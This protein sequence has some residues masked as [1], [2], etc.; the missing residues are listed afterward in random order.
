MVPT[1][2]SRVDAELGGDRAVVLA[3]LLLDVDAGQPD[4]QLADA[5]QVAL[6]RERQV[7]VAAPEVDDPQWVL[8][9]RS[10][11]VALVDGLG[12]R[13]VEQPEELLDLAVLRLPAGLDP[14]LVVGDAE[15]EEHRVVLG[16]QPLLRLVVTA[17]HLDR[18]APV[19][20]AHGRLEL[21]GHPQLVALR[22]GVDVPVAER[23]VEQRIDGVPSGTQSIQRGHRVVLGERLGLVVRRDLQVRP[24]P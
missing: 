2:N 11:Q 10:A 23:L 16:Q 17:L 20:G 6:G 9:G 24:R 7:G 21:L 1:T 5:G 22:G 4:G 8:E 13:A 3:R 18:R 15:H 14:A 12:D 19:G